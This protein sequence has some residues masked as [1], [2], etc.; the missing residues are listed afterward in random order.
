MD[1][2]GNIIEG[3]IY[4]YSLFMYIRKFLFEI[5]FTLKILL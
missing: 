1:M 3:L 5:C 4:F 2:R